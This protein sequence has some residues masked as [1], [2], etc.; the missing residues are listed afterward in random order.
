MPR[1]YRTDY[2]P[3]LAHIRHCIAEHGEEAGPKI[4]RAQFPKVDKGTWSRWCRQIRD[5][6]STMHASAQS[7]PAPAK[8]AATVVSTDQVEVLPE[9]IDFYEQ[10]AAM[11]AACDALVAYSWPRDSAT[12]ARKLRNPLML[13]QSIRMRAMVLDLWCRR[14]ESMYSAERFKHWQGQVVAAIGAALN[15]SGSEVERP[16]ALRIVDALR[17]L[18]A[19]NKADSVLIRGRSLVVDGGAA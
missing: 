8:A 18:D 19:R 1:P 7:L 6:D 5:E 14:E 11:V 12:G 4:A 10:V 15:G 2:L 13:S 17:A 3:A 9:T 16:V